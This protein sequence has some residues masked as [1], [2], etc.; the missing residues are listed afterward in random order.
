MILPINAY[1]GSLLINIGAFLAP[2]N[3]LKFPSQ[4]RQTVRRTKRSG[5][6][7]VWYTSIK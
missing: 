2:F 4:A 1:K 7:A 6:A 3:K 5:W